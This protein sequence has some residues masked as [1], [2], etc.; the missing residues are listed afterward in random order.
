MRDRAATFCGYSPAVATP[1]VKPW[2]IAHNP[3]W[4]LRDGGSIELPP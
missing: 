4:I 3:H 1:T 2:E